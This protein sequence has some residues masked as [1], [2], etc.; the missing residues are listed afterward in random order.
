MRHRGKTPPARVVSLDAVDAETGKKAKA[1][2]EDLDMFMVG[3]V[4]FF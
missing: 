4:I 1:S 2:F 3:G